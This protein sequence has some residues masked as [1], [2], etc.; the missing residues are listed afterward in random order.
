MSNTLE[1]QQKPFIYLAGLSR[2]GTLSIFTAMPKLGFGPTHHMIS[3]LYDKPLINA[4]IHAFQNPTT[5]DWSSLLK[6]FNSCIDEPAAGG[7]VNIIRDLL[8]A[9]HPVKVVIVKRDPEAWWKSWCNTSAKYWLP[10]STRATIGTFFGTFV[11][12]EQIRAR[13]WL[14]VLLN[15]KGRYHGPSYILEYHEHV[16]QYVNGINEGTVEIIGKDGKKIVPPKVEIMEYT[17]KE[18]WEPLCEF[19]GV[20]KPVEPFPRVND[21]AEFGKKW[22]MRIHKG[23]AILAIHTWITIFGLRF[24]RTRGLFGKGLALLARYK[25]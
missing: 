9:G 11:P 14:Q 22:W 7:Y 17:V 1:F 25:S 16:R 12:G 6:D 20:E 15:Y 8:A 13:Q 18:G 4:W 24:L 2:S 19:L 5:T 10:G 23:G 21:S 3:L